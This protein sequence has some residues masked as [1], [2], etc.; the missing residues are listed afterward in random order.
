MQEEA[1]AKVRELKLKLEL[2]EK[3]L[4]IKELE[5][6]NARMGQEERPHYPVAPNATVL[7]PTME[8]PALSAEPGQSVPSLKD[9]LKELYPIATHW[10][11]LGIF[12]DIDADLLSEIKSENDFECTAC[13]REL[14]KI[15][16]K[17]GSPPPSWAAIADAFDMLQESMRAYQLRKKYCGIQSFTLT[18]QNYEALYAQLHI[19]N[20][21]WKEIGIH[22]GFTE[23]ELDNIEARPRSSDL[24]VA[25]SC[26]LKTMLSEWLEWAPGDSRGSTKSAALED[27]EAVLRK[28]G[29]KEVAR[30]LYL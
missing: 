11:D 8:V 1:N 18:M 15:W 29:L 28:A 23:G 12:L 7:I 14:L 25:P 3:E 13:L 24:A 19:Y 10:E 16:L 4:K 30:G 22:L 21:K 20:T 26:W 6:K 17:K 27:L 5:L 2:Q 9:L